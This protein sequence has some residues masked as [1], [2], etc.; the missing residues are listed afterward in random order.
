M[1]VES[2]GTVLVMKTIIPTPYLSSDHFDPQVQFPQDVQQLVTAAN[3]Q[4]YWVSPVHATELLVRYSEDRCATWLTMQGS[5]DADLVRIMLENATVIDA[6]DPTAPPPPDGH[7]T[8]L[9]YAVDTMD[10]RQPHL[11]QLWADAAYEHPREAMRLAA[12]A[13]LAYLRKLAGLAD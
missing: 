13:E 4:G 8:W 11:E 9:D 3:N 2:V 5:S 6:P 10:T 12:Q 1:S 7:A